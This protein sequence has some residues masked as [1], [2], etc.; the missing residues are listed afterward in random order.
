MKG[1]LQIVL[2][3]N[4][5]YRAFDSLPGWART[6]VIGHSYKSNMAPEGATIVNI[7]AAFLR[8]AIPIKP[9]KLETKRHTAATPL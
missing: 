1:P 3:Y 4:S 2:K 7:Y 9:T 8:L 6:S 5:G